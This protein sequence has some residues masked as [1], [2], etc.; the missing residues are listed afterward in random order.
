MFKSFLKYLSFEKRYSEH[1]VLAYQSDLEQFAQF[2]STDFELK[3][4]LQVNNQVVRSWVIA[5]VDLGLEE[6]S[7]NRKIAALK[8][9]YKFSLKRGE[10]PKDPTTRVK[11]LK[12]SKKLPQFVN[13]EDILNILNNS[14]FDTGF[15]GAREKIV[16]EILYGTGIR[17]SELVNMKELDILSSGT[18][19]VLGKRNKER[20]LPIPSGV[21]MA[22]EEYKQ[23]KR[24]EFG[25]LP[26]D[27]LVVTDSGEKSYPMLIYRIVNDYLKRY[28]TI[29]KKSPHVLRH[30]FAT[31]LLNK[32][33]DL[34]AVKDLLGHTS[35]AATQVYTHNTIEKLKSVYQQAHPKA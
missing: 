29:E 9:Y 17:L 27:F 19:K 22:V 12:K 16:L 4:P 23:E 30:T 26:H 11:L 1:T 33:A 7:I 3:S 24:K 28:S 2:I 32:G 8:S 34:N 25:Q 5:L 6:S 31:H 14:T 13:Q 35:L 20:V 15:K 10:I 18:V 21:L